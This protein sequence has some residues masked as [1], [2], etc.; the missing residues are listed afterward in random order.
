[1][2]RANHVC[3]VP[4][5]Y[6]VIERFTQKTLYRRI[7]S[8]IAEHKKSGMADGDV[9]S[10]VAGR[11]IPQLQ[12]PSNGVEEGYRLQ[13]MRDH[14]ARDWGDVFHE[15]EN[16]GHVTGWFVNECL[17]ERPK[18]DV[19]SE[20]ELHL[21]LC[22]FALEAVRNLFA[23]VN[24]LRGALPQDV[25]G[26]WRTLYETLVH[27][28]FLLRFAFKDG[29]LPGR[30]LYHTN[31][32]YLRLYERFAT[33]GTCDPNN[34]W[35]ETNRRY[36]SRFPSGLGKGEY[37]WAYGLIR[38]KKGVAVSSERINFGRLID[39]VDK[40]SSWSDIY[41]D[42]ATSK[43]HGRFL[44]NPLLVGT[45]GSSVHVDGFSVGGVA[46]ALELVMPLFREIVE[47]TQSGC[48]TSKHGAVMG[49]VRKITRHV[50]DSIAAINASDP[51]MHG[52]RVE[53]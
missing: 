16:L 45:E 38:N 44:W 50:E 48:L 12:V 19:G 1:M 9:A 43:G 6:P 51:G 47:N 24:Q 29:D 20:D 11:L 5:H 2:V 33:V 15:L 52:G 36:A 10:I 14:V 26:Y 46:L 35:A 23:V 21:A 30:F 31:I 41:Y 49:V 8:E 4:S 17:W 28:R 18:V 27:S 22:L 34:V 3:T 40:G 39:A 42:V 25:F 13:Q 37:A 7:S 32:R 53:K